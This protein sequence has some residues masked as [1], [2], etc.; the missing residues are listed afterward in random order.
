MANILESGLEPLPEP[1]RVTG[2]W[3][4][5]AGLFIRLPVEKWSGEEAG[6]WPK[7]KKKKKQGFFC[8]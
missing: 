7:K 8:V 4:K 3:P 2:F 6:F 1:L 5:A